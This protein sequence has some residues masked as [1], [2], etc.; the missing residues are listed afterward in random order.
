MLNYLSSTVAPAPSRASLA[1]SASS[2]EAPLRMSDGAPSTSSLASFSPRLVSP[3]T[4]LITCIFCPPASVRTTSK[5]SFASSD[6]PSPPA[7]AAATATGAAAVTSNFSSN[8]SQ[9]SFNSKTDI[10]S[11]TDN[12]SS[13][14]IFAIVIPPLSLHPLILH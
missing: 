11:K 10:S 3:L 6:P 1:L 13:V 7:G 5:E 4:S 8:E 14:V 9:N 12:N 2:F